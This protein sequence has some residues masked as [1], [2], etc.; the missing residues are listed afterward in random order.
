M[1]IFS[2][3]SERQARRGGQPPLPVAFEAL[4]EALDSGSEVDA[5]L[6][7]IG[8][9]AAR[10]GT[11]LDDLLDDLAS[12]YQ[13]RALPASPPFDVVRRLAT[14][15]ADASL[16]YL[17]AVSCEDPITGLSSLAHVRSRISGMYRDAA[18][19]GQL[20]GP[21]Q[22]LLLVEIDWSW[23]APSRFDKVMRMID[24]AELVRAVYPGDETIAQL[25]GSRVVAIVGRGDQLGDSLNVL[26]GLLSD[27]EERS[28]LLTRLWI[29]G[30]PASIASAES[31]LDELAR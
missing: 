18:N 25:N 4:A 30:L 1:A 6:D 20:N 9:H 14:A 21:V 29:E 24:V 19:R 26:R 8:V 10:E 3:R 5:V 31:L 11:A 23:P 13:S 27:W 2:T 7:E 17:H 16:N 12:T 22:A 15:W 28:G